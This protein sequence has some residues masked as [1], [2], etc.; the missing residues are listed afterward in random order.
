[1]PRLF[2]SLR[3]FV[4]SPLYLHSSAL[5][6]A[7]RVHAP[8]HSLLPRLADLTEVERRKNAHH[9]E[10]ET[11]CN[12]RGVSRGGNSVANKKKASNQKVGKTPDEID[13]RRR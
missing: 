11:S 9:D 7:I 8:C 12:E 6:L 3:R 5:H 10:A 1:M 4:A 13:E 2:L